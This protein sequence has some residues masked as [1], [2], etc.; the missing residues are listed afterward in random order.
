MPASTI[1]RAIDRGTRRIPGLRRL[2]VLTVLAAAEVMVLA[3]D[4][5]TRL[6]PAE[7]RRVIEL[8]RIGRGRPSNLTDAQRAE[9]AGLIEKAEPR[10]FLGDAAD[11]LSPVPL[12]KR[13]LYGRR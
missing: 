10:A 11:R 7:R 5:V 9:L 3:H 8:V 1:Q 6:D 12:P 2:P 13:L 4:H